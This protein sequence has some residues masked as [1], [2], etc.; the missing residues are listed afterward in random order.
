[1][2]LEQF[3]GNNFEKMIK[4]LPLRIIQK[5][6]VAMITIYEEQHRAQ[7][8]KSWARTPSPLSGLSIFK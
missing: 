3:C 7:F 4:I 5:F 6:L 8:R 1:M 2:Q